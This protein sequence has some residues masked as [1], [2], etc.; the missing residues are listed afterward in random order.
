MKKPWFSPKKF[1]YGWGLPS[2]WQGWVVLVFYFAF[3]IYD[4]KRIDS[5]SHSAS[6]TLIN[7]IPQLILASV[8]LFF[9][10]RI[11]SGKPKWS[12]G[13]KITL[14]L[15]SIIL[16]TI[17]SIFGVR[18]AIRVDKA[19]QTFENYYA[20]RGC[21]KLLKKTNTYGLCRLPSGQTIKIVEFREKWYLD[22]DLP[23]CLANFCF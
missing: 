2:T 5:H 4:F 15:V 20:F 22:G 9:I 23:T 19:H 3:L 1:G 17:I 21:S 8:V 14:L 18:E 16:V 11:T 6:D 7:F 13:N 10:A 12:G